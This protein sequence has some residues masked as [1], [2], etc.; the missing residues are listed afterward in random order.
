[1]KTMFRILL[2]CFV[3]V[4]ALVLVRFWTLPQRVQEIYLSK[5][6]ARRRYSLIVYSGAPVQP[7]LIY[8][9]KV[10][11]GFF[12]IDRSLDPDQTRE[13]VQVLLDTANYEPYEPGRNWN[14]GELIF[15][16]FDKKGSQLGESHLNP[17]GEM[18][19]VP[20]ELIGRAGYLTSDGLK[21][22]RS[23]IE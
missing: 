8:R 15:I 3:I 12:A 19:T 18:L 20:L 23:T 22:L 1:M 16:Y 21:K 14:V 11:K 9:V 5:F 7:T 6:F 10:Y 2:I 17:A 4:V 13:L